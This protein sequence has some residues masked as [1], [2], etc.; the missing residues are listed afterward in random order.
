M[1]KTTKM[2]RL[3]S[4]WLLLL[5]MSLLAQ[6]TDMDSYLMAHTTDANEAFISNFPYKEYLKKI[7][8]TEFKTLQKHR[9]LLESQRGLGSSSGI[10]GVG[11]DFL[12]SLGDAFL[13][14]YPVIN[15][16]QQLNAKISIGEMFLAK[17]KE[18]SSKEN[19]IYQLI[20][21]FVLGKVAQTIEQAFKSGKFDISEENNEKTINRLAKSKVYLSI[22]KSE[23]DKLLKNIKTG[24]WDYLWDRLNK[25]LQ[26]VTSDKTEKSKLSLSD[27]K[28]KNQN[29]VEVFNIKEE[30]KTV[31]Y[32]IWM[33]R[34][35]VKAAYFAH[36]KAYNRFT[37]FSKTIGVK[38]VVL[39]TTGGFTNAEKQPE[40]LTIDNGNIV[41]AV[42]KP[43]RHAVVMIEKNGSMKVSNLKD[44][45]EIPGGT[46][47]LYP[48]NTLFDY[49]DLIKWAKSSKAT[50]FQTQL[51]AHGNQQLIELSRAPNQLRERRLYV[52][53]SDKDGTLY[54]LIFSINASK[55]LAAITEEIFDL[56]KKRN[57]TVEAILNLDVGSYNILRVLDANGKELEALRGPVS[58]YKA[59]NLIIF[60]K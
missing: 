21:Y 30:G 55:N 40:G 50:I 16:T 35:Q 19:E 59:T 29:G 60:Y 11:D 42:L 9:E 57:K 13:K 38:N 44:G 31:G 49:S 15:T 12:F 6:F 58:I 46:R 32:C 22:E 43:E 33:Q 53:A 47:K 39:A 4:F 51:L 17:K 5:P 45:I 56:L 10:G 34:P 48:L 52:L 23:W 2:I 54:N 7:A 24:Q 3:F 8:F 36:G 1:F 37:D 14:I 28:S 18:F 27:F 26:E 41:N 20:G 25:K